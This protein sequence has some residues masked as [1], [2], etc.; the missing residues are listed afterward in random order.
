VKQ[1]K[2]IE[3]QLFQ[4]NREQQDADLN[5]RWK[6]NV[7]RQIRKAP[8]NG[9]LPLESCIW[10]F[11]MATIVIALLLGCYLMIYGYFPESE[12]VA[13]FFE[14]AAGFLLNQPIGV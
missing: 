10:R 2:K 4:A 3:T 1:L 8:S 5:P 9:I 6:D 7:M 13:L 11:S 14:D 12:M